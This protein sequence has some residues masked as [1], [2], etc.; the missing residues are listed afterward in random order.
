[1][2]DRRFGTINKFGTTNKFG[3]ST[4]AAFFAWGVEV[5]WDGD[6]IFS[7]SN[8]A[9]YMTSIQVNRGR[10]QQI[11]STGGGFEQ[12]A[13][14]N[15]KIELLNNDGRYD[16][17]NTASVLYPNVTYG[18]DIRITVRDWST[19]TIEPVFYGI[20][21]DIAP[22]GYGGNRKVVI[23]ANDGW[24]FL[25]NYTAH[26]AVQQAIAPEDAIG[27]I[28]DNINWPA[29]WGRDL[30]ISTD[31]IPYWWA[32]GDKKAASEI[33]DVSESFLGNFFIN[34][35]G[36]AAYKLR[37]TV[38]AVA[39]DFPQEYIL[40][41]IANPQPWVNSRN[42][43]RLKVHPR[44][45]SGTVTLYQLIGTQP[46]VLDGASNALALFG[47]YN[48]NNQTVPALSIVAPVA[49]TDYTMNTAADG[50]GIDKTADCTVVAT[51]LGDTCK[52]V[53]TNNSGGSVYITKLQVRGVAVYEQNVTDVTCP[54]DP[55]TVTQPREFVLDLKWLQDVNIATD[56]AGVLSVYF[57]GLNPYPIIQIENRFAYQFGLDLFDTAVTQ[58]TELGISGISYKIGGI[59]H[60][61]YGDNCQQVVTKF[62]LEPYPFSGDYWA[63][64]TRSVFDT[65]VFGA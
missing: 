9:R 10:K 40:R 13:Q 12:I 2:A 61:S 48:Y 63:W 22:M 52:F 53:V 39:A 21:S 28:L 26:V 58:L 20:I 8:E 29:R 35:S 47:T 4:N 42:I 1:M 34:A 7:G 60:K 56:S 27:L 38:D 25:R 57:E 44:T 14:G 19:G 41:D 54:S 32:S 55:T 31:S 30:S 33:E 49:T 15:L 6:G 5:D 3:A 37:T 59:E 51:N 45:L 36:Q 23:T 62:Y 16:G 43:I 17:W 11:K 50:S 64:D 18:R 46:L 65:D 24:V